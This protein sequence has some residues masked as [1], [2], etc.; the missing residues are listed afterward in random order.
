MTVA[1][2]VAFRLFTF[3]AAVL[4]K[5][6]A[7]FADQIL[8]IGLPFTI[9]LQGFLHAAAALVVIGCDGGYGKQQCG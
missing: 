7:L 8:L 5:F 2:T 1:I 4:D 9:R 6:L 3:L